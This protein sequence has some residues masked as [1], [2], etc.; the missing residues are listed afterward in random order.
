MSGRARAGRRPTRTAGLRF[1]GD[2]SPAPVGTGRAALYLRVSGVDQST[3][4]QRPELERL[5]R[6]RDLT[7]VAVY[8]EQASAAKSRSQFEAMMGDA[9]HG[10]F[11]VLLVWALDRFG[12]SMVGNMTAVL[13][14]DRRG[15]QVVSLREPW[16]D[17]GGPVRPLLVAIF[18][19]VAEQERAQ[20]IARTH[21]GLDRARRRGIRLGRPLARI[22][23]VLA[24]RLRAAGEPLRAIAARLA[25]P[26]G[27]LHGALRRSEKGGPGGGR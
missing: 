18:S 5:A 19:W 22:D 3:D 17:T 25:V 11:D 9:H 2:A 16:L 10:A 14:L 21:A 7:I 27:T 6:A 4:N 24:R 20:L 13:E 8:D 1:E 23:L 15:V 12:R 26:L